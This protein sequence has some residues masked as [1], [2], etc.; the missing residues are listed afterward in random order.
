M[1]ACTSEV[2][3]RRGTIA[4]QIAR[5]RSHAPQSRH[6][7]CSKAAYCAD[8][9]LALPHMRSRSERHAKHL[10]LSDKAA[11]PVIIAVAAR[12]STPLPHI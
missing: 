8:L 5:F 4:A 7:R 12:L 9:L 10:R 2:P 3:I 6:I 11:L 1:S